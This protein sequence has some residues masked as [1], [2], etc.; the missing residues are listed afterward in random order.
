[1]FNRIVVVHECDA[2]KV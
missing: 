2:T 1:M